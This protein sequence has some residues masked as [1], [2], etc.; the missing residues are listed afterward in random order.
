VSEPASSAARPPHPA[1]IPADTRPADGATRRSDARIGRCSV[2]AT[3]LGA[4]SRRRPR[5]PERGTSSSVSSARSRSR[6][7]V[8]T[9]TRFATRSSSS[10]SPSRSAD[11]RDS[12]VEVY[13]SPDGD[14]RVP[15][16]HPPSC[17][18]TSGSRATRS[19]SSLPPV[20]SVQRERHTLKRPAGSV[21]RCALL[22]MRELSGLRCRL[23]GR[24]WQRGR[25]CRAC[26]SGRGT[27]AGHGTWS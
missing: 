16:Y 26:S 27:P 22:M 17:H 2:S 18:G 21:L 9:R 5:R 20:P 15:D 10:R 12:G 1:R 13:D 11:A 4:L 7:A 25:C 14:E 23:A 24:V 19:P 3:S 6:C 8:A